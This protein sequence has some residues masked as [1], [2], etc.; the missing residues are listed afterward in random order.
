MQK[1]LELLKYQITLL[2]Q[3]VNIDEMPFNDFLIDHDISK[4]QHKWIIDVMKILN[5][6]F[7]YVK[8]ATDDY[9]NSVTD[10]F[11]KDYQFTEMNFNQFFEIKLPTFKEFDAVISKNLPADTENLYMLKAMKNQQMFQELC[12]HLI[13]GAKIEK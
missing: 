1:E 9:Y 12:T 4:E 2:K 7:S 3:M 5:Y 11:S 8:D 10:Q 13:E 6:R